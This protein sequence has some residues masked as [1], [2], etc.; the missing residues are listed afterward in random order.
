MENI[1]LGS[2]DFTPTGWKEELLVG[3]E[4]FDIQTFAENSLCS[5]LGRKFIWFLL[6]MSTE[7]GLVSKEVANS[8][9]DTRVHPST[10]EPQELSILLIFFL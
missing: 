5:Q 7:I 8:I 6:R 4:K 3:S 2:R 10:L 1:Q 9:L